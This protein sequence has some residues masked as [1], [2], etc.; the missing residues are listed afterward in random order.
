M[1]TYK[2]MNAGPAIFQLGIPALEVDRWTSAAYWRRQQDHQPGLRLG[3]LMVP[4][5]MARRFGNIT[6]RLTPAKR[7]G[8]APVPLSPWYLESSR[9]PQGDQSK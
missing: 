3:F 8:L 9:P 6:A 1:K 7:F 2:E 4:I 5:E